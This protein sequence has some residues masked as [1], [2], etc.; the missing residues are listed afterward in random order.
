MRYRRAL[1]I[2]A[3]ALAAILLAAL[4][5]SG[6]ARGEPV[7]RE[8]SFF[9]AFDTYTRLTVYADSAEQAEEWL[10]FAREELTAYHRLYDIYHEYEGLVNLCAVNR[11]AAKGPVKV[12]PRLMGLLLFCKEM[13]AMTEGRVNI[14]MGGVLRL[15]HEARER[16]LENPA[17]AALPDRAALEAAASHA[18]I[19]SLVLNEKEGTVYFADP[20]LSLDVGAVA[21]GYATERTAEAMMD[22]GVSAALMSVGG[23][24]RAIG[25]RGDGGAYRA[26]IQNPDLEA[27]EQAVRVVPLRGASLV[28]S[29][30]YQRFYTVGEARYHHIIDPDTLMPAGYAWSVTVLAEDGGLAD[31][32]S[33]ALFTLPVEKGRA[34]LS[35]LAGAEALWVETDGTVAASP[36]FP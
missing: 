8:L 35:S 29:G 13:Y 32:L 12:D 16:G 3:L 22:K 24:V 21:K 26:A 5:T 33:T 23:N 34:L 25:G 31:A 1:P 6:P 17:N 15:W 27:D 18:G 36:G 9:D 10:A 11:L 2:C 14:A 19:D 30:G 20:L 7:R 4:G 28:T